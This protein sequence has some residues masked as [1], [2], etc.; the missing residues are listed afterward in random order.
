MLWLISSRI[1]FLIWKTPNTLLRY[2]ILPKLQNTKFQKK[3]TEQ[4]SLR[5]VT[6]PGQRQ[7]IRNQS[8]IMAWLCMNCFVCYQNCWRQYEM[9]LKLLK[10]H[11]HS[12]FSVALL[13]EW[14]NAAN[15]GTFPN[16]RLAQCFCVGALH[17][18]AISD[19]HFSTSLFWLV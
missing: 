12:T 3:R 1:F 16:L 5:I 7:D 11:I 4:Q 17:S 18:T 15:N 13:R 8:Q 19:N 9:R 14:D 6:Y 2:F 10:L